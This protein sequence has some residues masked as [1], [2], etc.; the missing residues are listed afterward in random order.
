MSCSPI[1]ARTLLDNVATIDIVRDPT[2]ELCY[3]L[4]VATDVF[5]C[6]DRECAGRSIQESMVLI[7]SIALT[8]VALLAA[9]VHS[10]RR[11]M[12]DAVRGGRFGAG[13]EIEFNGRIG[14]K[15]HSRFSPDHDNAP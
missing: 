2:F 13:K 12:G 5:A 11:I 1:E 8:D 15:I 3:P 7:G 9:L 4:P 14:E 10:R 6:V